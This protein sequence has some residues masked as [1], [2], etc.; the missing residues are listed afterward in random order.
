VLKG[1][2]NSGDS[3]AQEA[4]VAERR[5]LAEVKHPNIVDV[6]NFVQHPDSRSGA[7]TGYIVMEYVGGQ[8]LRE[9][10]LDRR[11]ATGESLPL[12]EA[13]AYAIEVLPALGYLHNRGLVYCDFKPDNV[14]QTE[15][16][17][18]LIDMGGVRRIDDEESAIL[19][20]EGFQAPEIATLGPSPSSDL[21]TVGR[22]LAVLTFEF[23]GFQ[24]RYQHSLPDPATVRVLAANDS[25]ARALRRAT[26]ADRDQ[27]FA[28]AGEMAEQLTGV[29]REVVSVAS[30]EPHPAFSA[31]FTGEAHAIGTPATGVDHTAQQGA[32]SPAE[33][34]SGLPVPVVDSGDPAAGFLATLSTLEPAH[35]ISALTAAM[36]AGQGAPPG[37]AESVETRLALARAVIVSGNPSDAQSPLDY[38]AARRPADWRVTWYRGLLALANADPDRARAAFESVLDVL[39]GEVAP[40]LALGLAAESA[41]DYSTAARFLSVVWTVDRSFVSA[42]FGLARVRTKTGD[43]DGAVAALGAVP[44]ASSQY[45]AAQVAALRMR[46][47]PPAGQD[48]VSA[49]ELQEAARHFARLRPDPELGERLKSELLQAALARVLG[50][51]P[52]DAASLPGI[53]PTERAV[54]FGLEKSYREQARRVPDVDRRI[55]LVD[56]ANTVRPRTWS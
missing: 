6:Y 8:S 11:A 2:L 13:L 43:I 27:R 39:P 35:L 33:I 56:M 17:L 36:Y 42:A 1:L 7:L 29:L 10:L 32:P 31:L 12:A 50:G 9:I 48:W 45:L 54:R 28:S 22:T 53:D 5:F 23:A 49:P 20:T 15:E 16:Q 40:K 24:N 51:Q 55:A 38:V 18:Q 34:V 4:A 44:V 19:G 3:A 21:Y 52:V 26:N 46:L 25:F 41:G 30:G 47:C 37:V 14:I